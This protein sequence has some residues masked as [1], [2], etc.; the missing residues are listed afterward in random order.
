M[1]SND[2]PC[3]WP[4]ENP[5]VFLDYELPERLIAQE[6]A[7]ERDQAR[8]LL[9]RRDRSSL[10]HYQFSEL[11][12]LLTAGDLLILNDTRVLPARLLG[13]RAGTG[14]KWEG[15]F[16]RETD[17]G[18]WE[19]VCQTRGKLVPGEFIHID[20]G[21][22]ELELICKETEGRWLVRPSHSGTPVELLVRHGRIPLPPYIRRGHAGPEDEERY[23]TVYAE[24]VGAIAAPTAG[25]H[26]TPGLLDRLDTRGIDR[27]FVTLH[28][29]R[30]TFQPIQSEDFRQHRMHAEWG[31]L[32]QETV[33]KI[34]RCRARGGRVVAVGTTSVR[35]LETVAGS[36]PI[37][38]WSGETEL[39]IVPG[40]HFMAVDALVTNF[41]LPRTSLLLLVQAFAGVELT[42]RAYETAVEQNYR[43]YSYGDAMLIL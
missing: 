29:G 2:Y 21:P 31:Q 4:S 40:H 14:G 41:H 19:I 16:L 3:D 34:A 6:P 9:L 30:G 17:V 12:E 11:P 39:F 42:R 37:R 28:V 7:R 8:L 24:H 32:P 26:F 36:G 20:P 1:P 10:T 25:L 22:L 35:V 27:A 13:R 18:T 38:P 15:L 23:Q 5:Q 33:E 43:F